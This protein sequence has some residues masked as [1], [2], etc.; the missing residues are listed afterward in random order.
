M[1]VW[2]RDTKVISGSILKALY[3]WTLPFAHTL[4]WP[5]HCISHYMVKCSIQFSAW[6]NTW[7]LVQVE[8]EAWLITSRP[9]SPCEHN[10]LYES[11]LHSQPRGCNPYNSLSSLDAKMTLDNFSSLVFCILSHCLIQCHIDL[12]K[13]TALSLGEKIL[14]VS[15]MLFLKHKAILSLNP[16][17]SL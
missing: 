17:W 6:G 1:P 14:H 2:L 15:I 5:C 3:L 13:M 11:A 12:T 16:E 10:I 8:A 4:C 9:Y 7:E